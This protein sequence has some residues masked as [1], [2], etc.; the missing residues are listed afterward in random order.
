MQAT[1]IYSD[2]KKLKINKKVRDWFNSHNEFVGILEGDSLIIKKNHSLLDF[3]STPDEEYLS[4]EDINEE[5]HK[6]RK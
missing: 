5:V 3:A 2:G 4:L 6:M 1:T